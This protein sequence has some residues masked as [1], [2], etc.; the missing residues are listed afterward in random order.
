MEPFELAREKFKHAKKMKFD[1]ESIEIATPEI[2]AKYRAKRLA[3]D[4][5]IDMCCGIA[6]DTIS[7][8]ET[9][10]N[11]IAIDINKQMIDFAKHNCKT[12]GKN[13]ISFIHG[14]ALEINIKKF[15]ANYVFSDPTRRI[16]GK[17]VKELSETIPPVDQIVKKLMNFK[18]F[19]I[20]VSQQLK[21]DQI[22]YDC[23]REYLSYN[24][25]CS[26]LS[27]YF[28]NLKKCERSSI[29]L[30]SELRLESKNNQK[31]PIVTDLKKFFY[32]ID[33]AIIKA[34]L[35]GELSEEF[36]FTSYE[37]F[38]TSD[39]KI[40]SPYIKNSFELLAI[41]RK[42]EIIST[43]KSF[44]ANKVVLRGKLDPHEQPILKRKIDSCLF[45][46]EK[47]H[48]FFNKKI[49]IARCLNLK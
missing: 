40:L 2:F 47:L 13:N 26:C 18:G 24:G 20:E 11:V 35:I 17:R 21:P 31:K 10:K 46:K 36:N 29:I 37:N 45:G 5:I 42:E 33:P 41:V 30:P 16:K 49:I 9:C 27:L 6:G 28:G 23:E 44:D 7:L 14:D 8:A 15:N 3:C 25:E 48:V 34:D 32:E 4:S 12:H 1:K 19:C 38:L 43:L 22:P 39:E